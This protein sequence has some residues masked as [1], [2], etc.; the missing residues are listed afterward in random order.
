VD[1]SKC[2]VGNNFDATAEKESPSETLPDGFSL[3]QNYPNPFNPTTQIEYTIPTSEHV[4]LEI[5]NINGQLVKTLV[6]EVVSSGTHTVEWDATSDSGNQVAT[7][8]YFYRLTAGDITQTKKM[9]F[10]K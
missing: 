8:I 10:L 2:K 5:Y 4:T 7:G 6:D 9:S 3:A 1:S